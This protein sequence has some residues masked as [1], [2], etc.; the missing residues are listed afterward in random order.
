M[1][2]HAAWVF[3]WLPIN[4]V[5]IFS[6]RPEHLRLLS[7]ATLW[8]AR[9]QEKHLSCQPVMC[10]QQ[11]REEAFILFKERADD[12]DG[13]PLTLKSKILIPGGGKLRESVWRQVRC[14]FRLFTRQ[15]RCRISKRMQA[16][17]GSACANNLC[18]ETC[19]CRSNYDSLLLFVVVCF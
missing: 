3:L 7:S 2:T 6:D 8:L 13:R 5:S 17:K 4:V 1:D 18:G 11:Q 16:F 12:R 9:L 19:K 15:L 10:S 14:D